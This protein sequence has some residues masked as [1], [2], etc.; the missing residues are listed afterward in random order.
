MLTF[1]LTKLLAV[2]V[3][4]RSQFAKVALLRI[5]CAMLNLLIAWT[6]WGLARLVFAIF[7]LSAIIVTAFLVSEHGDWWAN[8]DSFALVQLRWGLEVN[9]F[10]WDRGILVLFVYGFFMRSLLR[11]ITYW[12]IW[13]QLRLTAFYMHS[14]AVNLRVIRLGIDVLTFI[15][16]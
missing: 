4:F 3:L 12:C 11:T 9:S 6:Y 13:L 14:L 15:P 16:F 5:D 1:F 2:L 8:I 10:A 7:I